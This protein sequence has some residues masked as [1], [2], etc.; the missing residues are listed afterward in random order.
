MIFQI[1]QFCL[2][3][4]LH[5]IVHNKGLTRLTFARGFATRFCDFCRTKIFASLQND[6]NFSILKEPKTHF[7]LTSPERFLSRRVAW[8]FRVTRMSENGNNLAIAKRRLG[9]FS[10]ASTNFLNLKSQTFLLSHD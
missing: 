10:A 9:G 8:L 1:G 7:R 6:A 5:F 3:C 2:F 4:I